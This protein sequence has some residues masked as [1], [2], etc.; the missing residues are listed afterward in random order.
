VTIVET[1]RLALRRFEPRDAP[2]VLRLLNEPS[3]I[4]H[5]GNKGVH[6]VDDAAKYLADGPIAMYERVGFGLYLVELKENRE[7]IGMCGLIKRDALPD[8]DVGFAFLPEHWGRGFAYESTMAVV[9]YGHRTLGLS[10]IVAIVSKTNPRS[11]RLLERLGFA[12]EGTTSVSPD[13]ELLLFA[14]DSRN[15]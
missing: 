2:F 9:D 12:S 4:E 11:A 15:A 7:P 6:T 13:E 1:E 5:I 14:S 3:W 8:V 10:R